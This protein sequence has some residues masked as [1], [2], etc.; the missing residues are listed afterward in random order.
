VSLAQRSAGEGRRVCAKVSEVL[1]HPPVT[2][3]LRLHD[4]EAATSFCSE[5]GRRVLTDGPFVDS[6]DYLAGAVIVETAS[7]DGA[8]A[9]AEELQDI[10]GVCGSNEIRAVREEP[11]VGA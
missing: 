6:T 4:L 2:D 7:I 1:D 10:R 9:V 8:F 11:R 5:R 3:W